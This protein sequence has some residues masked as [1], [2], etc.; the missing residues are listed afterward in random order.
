MTQGQRGKTTLLKWLAAG[1]DEKAAE[2]TI[3]TRTH[4]LRRADHVPSLR[5]AQLGFADFSNEI[6]QKSAQ[7]KNEEAGYQAV[8]NIQECCE[9]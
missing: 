5:I 9:L 1:S 2:K 8:Q 3:A 6:N 7:A 4:V